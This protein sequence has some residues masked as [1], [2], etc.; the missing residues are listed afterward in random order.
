MPGLQDRGWQVLSP[1]AAF[2]RPRSAPSPVRRAAT[3]SPSA[4]TSCHDGCIRPA[5]VGGVR[6]PPIAASTDSRARRGS[7]PR[8]RTPDG[9]RSRGND[10]QHPDGASPTTNSST[11]RAYLRQR[12][13]RRSSARRDSSTNF[14]STR[15]RQQRATTSYV[16]DPQLRET[17]RA[18]GAR[19]TG[20]FADRSARSALAPELRRR[21]PQHHLHR[22]RSRF[23]P[24]IRR[25][26]A[27]ATGSTSTAASMRI[28]HRPHRSIRSAGSAFVPTPGF[29][30]SP[31]TLNLVAPLRAAANRQRRRH[32]Q[33]P[34]RR[35]GQSDPFRV[36]LLAP[37]SSLA[38]AERA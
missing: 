10:W 11:I 12:S 1:A 27:A 8:M 5:T 16:H 20:D 13:R 23:D 28:R 17:R 36:Q 21:E 3:R 18:D 26:R 22:A 14:G 35:D 34:G 4:C 31:A 6:R 33:Q 24:P 32:D 19:S 9:H 29:S 30:R 25:R 38:R 2:A 7:T 37:P 15:R